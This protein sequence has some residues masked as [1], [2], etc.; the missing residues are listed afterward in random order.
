VQL[1][2]ITYKSPSRLRIALLIVW[3][4]AWVG[5]GIPWTGMTNHAHW[6]VIR[7]SLIPP[8]RSIVDVILNFAFYI[9]LGL[10]GPSFQRAGVIIAIG[11]ACSVTTELI[12]VFSHTRTPTLLDVVVNTAGAIVGA[13]LQSRFHSRASAR[14]DVARSQ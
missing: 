8:R 11:F 1:R 10:L 2:D 13:V 5:F 7:W 4:L 9:P 12:Q 6:R 14:E 3:S